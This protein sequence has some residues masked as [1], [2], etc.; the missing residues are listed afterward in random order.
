MVSLLEHSH[1]SCL[2][3]GN[4]QID[5]AAERSL[6]HWEEEECVRGRSSEVWNSE[7]HWSFS[8]RLHGCVLP[9]VNFQYEADITVDLV[10]LQCDTGL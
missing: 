7:S 1:Y 2:T 6:E 10:P 3:S 4:G 8:I 5:S 9:S